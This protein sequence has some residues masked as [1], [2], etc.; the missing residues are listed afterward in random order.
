MV[1]D[2]SPL[3]DLSLLLLLILV[4]QRSKGHNP[5]RSVLSSFTDE[6]DEKKSLCT[7]SVSYQKL[8]TTMCRFVVVVLVMVYVVA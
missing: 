4:H 5:F 1:S 7:F 6:H 8:Y 2:T 3:A